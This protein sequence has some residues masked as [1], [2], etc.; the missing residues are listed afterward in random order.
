MN[1]QDFCHLIEI[2]EGARLLR[3]YRIFPE[4]RRH[5]FTETSLPSRT[6]DPTQYAEFARLVKKLFFSTPPLQGDLWG[7]EVELSAL[8]AVSRDV[9]GRASLQEEIIAD[10]DRLSRV[11]GGGG[12]IHVEL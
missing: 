8:S 11:H 1:E 3:I 4:G 5:L 2:D 9:D 7:L 6:A 12:V 10:D